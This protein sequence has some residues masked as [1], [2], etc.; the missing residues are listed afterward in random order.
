[1]SGSVPENAAL[2]IAIGWLLIVVATLMARSF[3]YFVEYWAPKV[4][5][6]VTSR[7]QDDDDGG[8]WNKWK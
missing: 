8:K 3:V 1:M 5:V 6:R 4:C 7:L 2:R